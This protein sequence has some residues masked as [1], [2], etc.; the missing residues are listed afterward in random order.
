MNIYGSLIVLHLIASSVWVGVQVVLTF[1]I[2]PQG[3]KE[4]DESTLYRIGAVYSSVGIPALLFSVMTGLILSYLHLPDFSS[5]LDF[6]NPMGRLIG[7]KVSLLVLMLVLGLDLRFRLFPKMGST[8]LGVMK[9]HMALLTVVSVLLVVVGA[10]F[11]IG[12]L[13]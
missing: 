2:L 8:G 10:S 9:R 13:Y 5:W 4:R 1:S 7:M 12:W 6:D 3:V 11:R